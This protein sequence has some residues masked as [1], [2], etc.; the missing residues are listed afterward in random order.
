MVNRPGDVG[1]ARGTSGGR[2]R[3][4]WLHNYTGGEWSRL[5]SFDQGKRAEEGNDELVNHALQTTQ[6]PTFVS[7]TLASLPDSS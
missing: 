7:A 6:A 2:M 1:A 5:R 3:L 4:S